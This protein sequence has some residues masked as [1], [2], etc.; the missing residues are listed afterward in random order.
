VRKQ[1]MRGISLV[2]VLGLAGW[3]LAAPSF[4][5]GITV[6]AASLTGEAEVPGPGDANGTGTALITL[7]SVQGTVC[8]SLDWENIRSPFMAHIH[9]GAEDVAGPIKV[10]LFEQVNQIPLDNTITGVD[11]CVR[12]VDTALIGRIASNPSNFYVNIHNKPFPAGAIRGQ[13]GPAV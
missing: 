2:V 7:D 9:K 5:G 12:D 13:L 1:V 11:G 3:L 6:L 4:A 10:V 8:F